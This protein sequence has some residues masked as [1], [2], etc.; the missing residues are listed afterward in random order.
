MI[1][2]DEATSS[3]IGNI[4][5]PIAAGSGA[6]GLSYFLMRDFAKTILTFATE[7]ASMKTEV[8]G[9]KEEVRRLRDKIDKVQP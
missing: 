5:P 7:I 3:V 9:M 4:L 6:A 2:F 1:I 8:Q